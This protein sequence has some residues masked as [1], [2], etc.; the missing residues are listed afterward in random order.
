MRMVLVYEPGRSARKLS[1]V[2]LSGLTQRGGIEQ[3]RNQET[4]V[5]AHGHLVKL[6]RQFP[7]IFLVASL[8]RC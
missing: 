7:S 8:L 5:L 4:K 6:A 2:A 3:P 1:L